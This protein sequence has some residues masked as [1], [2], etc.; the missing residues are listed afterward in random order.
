[1]TDDL[2]TIDTIYGLMAAWQSREV[3]GGTFVRCGRCNAWDGPSMKL[4]GHW[5]VCDD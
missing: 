1:M 4:M 5:L 3:V 2:R